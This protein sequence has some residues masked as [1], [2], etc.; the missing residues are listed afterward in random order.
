MVQSK[1]KTMKYAMLV[2]AGLWLAACADERGFRPKSFPA[3]T[4][5]AQK[6]SK[7]CNCDSR[8]SS[9]NSSASGQ[10]AGTGGQAVIPSPAGPQNSAA[11]AP[12]SNSGAAPVKQKDEVLDHTLRTII[13]Q[14]EPGTDPAQG[15]EKIT[16]NLTPSER[17]NQV[18][19]G[20]DINYG[21]ASSEGTMMEVKAVINDDGGDDKVVTAQGRVL[22]GVEKLIPLQSETKNISIQA[23][24]CLPADCGGQHPYLR[25]YM[26]VFLESGETVT[27]VFMQAPDKSGQY[28]VINST[29]KSPFP[30][31]DSVYSAKSTMQSIV[32]SGETSQVK[33][34]PTAAVKKAVRGIEKS[35]EKDQTRLAQESGPRK[36]ESRVAQ[37]PDSKS[38]KAVKTAGAAQPKALQ[39]SIGGFRSR[40]YKV[41]HDNDDSQS[42]QAP[43]QVKPITA[44]DAQKAWDEAMKSKATTLPSGTLPSD[45]LK[46]SA[47]AKVT[48]PS[49]KDDATKAL[50]T[51]LAETMKQMSPKTQ[52]ANK[53]AAPVEQKKESTPQTQPT[54]S[55]QVDE[56]V[57]ST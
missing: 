2:L 3:A 19:K 14:L 30:S 10:Q 41:I 47:Q 12:G 50:D 4:D 46:Q 44:A 23:Y 25:V 40:R 1:V 53:D 49:T 55:T 33:G 16:R 35:G 11:P 52:E 22:Y 51:A 38:E 17:A 31:V 13:E 57:I 18:I 45:V 36:D 37:E 56:S 15:Q 39:A 7:N 42:V 24:F 43:V 54:K 26:H 32:K 48:P 20:M 28:T 34:D 9:Q 8:Q 29:I 5:Q 27:A 6:D 21:D